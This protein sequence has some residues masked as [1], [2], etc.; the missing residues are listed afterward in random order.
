MHFELNPSL[1]LWPRT[2]ISSVQTVVASNGDA[3]Y[4]C[5]RVVQCNHCGQ[6]GWLDDIRFFA[7]F[8]LR[9]CG[10]VCFHLVQL[11][12]CTR[13]ACCHSISWFLG[14]KSSSRRWPTS[15]IQK[16]ERVVLASRS[17]DGGW[18]Q[19]CAASKLSTVTCNGLRSWPAVDIVRS[20]MGEVPAI[21]AAPLDLAGHSGTLAHALRN[22][23]A[24]GFSTKVAC[25]SATRAAVEFVKIVSHLRNYQPC[26]PSCERSPS[27]G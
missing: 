20:A 24:P 6:L 4:C 19:R 12:S 26:A 22:G 27:Q 14:S 2:A 16:A 11:H 13:G 5:G 10:R 18:Q 1:I 25:S 9:G 7:C 21:K 8:V 3:A 15:P 23:S 17:S